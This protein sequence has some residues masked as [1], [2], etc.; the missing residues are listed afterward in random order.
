[1]FFVNDKI[2]KNVLVSCDHGLMIVNRFDFDENKVGNGQFLLD[3]GNNC[4]LEAQK[5]FEYIKNKENPIIFDIGANIGT[6]STWMARIFPN[7][8][9]YSFEPQRIIFQMLCGNIAINN[10]DNCYT[11][12]AAIGNINGSLE[13]EE[14]NYYK[15]QSFGNYNVCDKTDNIKNIIDIFKLD[16]FTKKYKIKNVDFIKID[17]EGMDIEVLIGAM[18][19]LKRQKP[20][21]LIEYTND[22]Q[23][24]LDEIIKIL[25]DIN[26]SFEILDRNILAKPN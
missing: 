20:S 22:K 3:H 19:I 5:S 7:G 15:Q 13:I 18:N 1:M 17:V 12:N 26:Y 16:Y 11:Y 14:P 24:C 21:L 9:I 2:N 23:S 25:K 4:T 8:K 6:Y 10:F